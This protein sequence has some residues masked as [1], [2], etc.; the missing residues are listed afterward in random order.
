MKNAFKYSSKFWNRKKSLHAADSGWCLW[1]YL[2]LLCFVLAFWV[3]SLPPSESTLGLCWLLSGDCP[4]LQHLSPP[5]IM[6][7]GC[8]KLAA[9]QEEL[10]SL[11]SDMRWPQWNNT[12]SFPE[13]ITTG[14]W[15]FGVLKQYILGNCWAVFLRGSWGQNRAPSP[16]SA[17]GLT[18]PAS[19]YSCHHQLLLFVTH[20]SSGHFYI[21]LSRAL[22][23]LLLNALLFIL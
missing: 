19:P 21:V 23:H 9:F 3:D 11:P 2:N 12:D 15:A 5:D 13:V 16:Q 1:L 20:C 6:L 17:Y 4:R 10:H 8:D 14:R 18:P 22:P 7:L